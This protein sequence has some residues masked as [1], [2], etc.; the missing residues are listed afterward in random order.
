MAAPSV[1]AT[2]FC[3]ASQGLE[4]IGRPLSLEPLSRAAAAS[5]PA[6]RGK[7]ACGREPFLFWQYCGQ[8][9][10]DRF[11][12]CRIPR[13]AAE[14]RRAVLQPCMVGCQ[15]VRN[16]CV[17]GRC[18]GGRYARQ[19]RCRCLGFSWQQICRPASAPGGPQ[20]LMQ[21]LLHH[22]EICKGVFDQVQTRIN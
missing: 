5:L 6:A 20:K 11:Q 21:A 12:K 10:Q 18:L 16:I 9:T 4:T 3:R 15:P 22:R 14:P 2:S 19:R 17:P 1:R 13:A 8:V 7:L